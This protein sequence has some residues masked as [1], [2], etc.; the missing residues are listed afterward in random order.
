MILELF[1]MWIVVGL[2]AGYLAG[3]L[4]KHGGYGLNGDLGLGVIGSLVA[5][6]L[7]RI[8]ELSPGSGWFAVVVVA[9]IGAAI[10]IGGQRLLWTTPT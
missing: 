7:F 2:I 5:S 8:T 1:G 10:V 4:M 3:F 9:F 6:G